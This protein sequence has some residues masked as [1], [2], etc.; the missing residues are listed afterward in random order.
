MYHEAVVEYEKAMQLIIDN[1]HALLEVP[2]ERQA[3]TDELDSRLGKA[4]LKAKILDVQALSHDIRQLA[5]ELQERKRTDMDSDEVDKFWASAGRVI[6]E[7]RVLADA[8]SNDM[9]S[10]QL[11]NEIDKLDSI[12]TDAMALYDSFRETINQA[13]ALTRQISNDW[14]WME[15]KRTSLVDRKEFLEKSIER[16]SKA[17]EDAEPE[18]EVTII[19]KNALDTYQKLYGQIKWIITSSD[20]ESE[21]VLTNR[22]EAS[23]TIAALLEVI[24]KRRESLAAVAKEDEREKE[25]QRLI[26]AIKQAIDMADKFKLSKEKKT[27]EEQLAQTSQEEK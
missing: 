3:L 10:L 12:L 20:S 17:L 2:E 27:L 26:S 1:T 22:D 15:R 23:E 4:L 6:K 18:S 24:P 7:S 19:L 9:L 13:I 11:T 14:H 21:E 25:R 5:E 8:Q 16:I